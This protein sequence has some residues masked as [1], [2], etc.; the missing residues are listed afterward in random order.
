MVTDKM[1]HTP[2]PWTTD[3]HGIIIAAPTQVSNTQSRIAQML[4]YHCPV[5]PLREMQ[6]ANAR[7]IAAAPE[8]AEALRSALRALNTVEC[9]LS[10]M[11]LSVV[12]DIERTLA[13]AGL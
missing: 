2:G 5:K 12:A 6:E 4:D 8:M 1:K 13:K 10:S 11:Q 7:L 3:L 9:S